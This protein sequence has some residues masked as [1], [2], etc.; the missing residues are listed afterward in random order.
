MEP[1]IAQFGNRGM[2]QDTSISKAPNEFA[3]E[4]RNIR[5]TAINGDTLLSVTN[6]K[7]PKEI[8]LKDKDSSAVSLEGIC[9]GHCIL[10][11]YIVL[12]TKDTNDYIYRLEDKGDYFEVQL[13][14]NGIFGFNLSNPIEAIGYYESEDIQKIYWVDGINQPRLINIIQ[15]A[16]SVITIGSRLD[17]VSTV[18]SFPVIQVEK[19]FGGQGIFPSGVIQYF[20]TQYNKFGAETAIIAASDINYI[21]FSDRGGKADET[22]NCSFNLTIS[23]V[24]TQFDYVRIYSAKRTTLNGPLEVQIVA[25]IPTKDISVSTVSVTDTNINQQLVDSNILYYL[26]GEEFIASTLEQK[27]NTL[28]FGNLKLKSTEFPEI[29][30]MQAA[31]AIYEN[32]A[33][34]GTLNN[35]FYHYDYQ[36]KNRSSSKVKY[37]KGG[38]TY[39]FGIQFLN[40][41]GKWSP[42]KSLGDYTVP[43]TTRPSEE[44]GQIKIPMLNYAGTNSI[45]SSEWIGYRILRAETSINTRRILAQGMVN[46][47]VFNYEERCNN[48]PYAISSW[49]TR[50]MSSGNSTHYNNVNNPIEIQCNQNDDV[51][52]SK[53]AGEQDTLTTKK[54]VAVLNTKL[55][56]GKDY[57]LFRLLSVDSDAPLSSLTA[58]DVHEIFSYSFR[59]EKWNNAI[60][61]ANAYLHVK[62]YDYSIGP[63]GQMIVLEEKDDNYGSGS[64]E[65][66]DVWAPL[67]QGYTEYTDYW[68]AYYVDTPSGTNVTKQ[69]EYF[70]DTSIVT[71]NSPEFDSV[72]NVIDDNDDIKFRIVGIAE[73]QN[74]F[75]GHILET[76]DGIAPF[77]STLKKSGSVDNAGETLTSGP[78]YKDGT[79]VW[80]GVFGITELQKTF[81]TQFASTYTIYMWHKTGQIVGNNGDW[82]NAE[83][84]KGSDLVHKIF[85]TERYS[86]NTQYFNTGGYNMN[87]CAPKAFSSNEITSVKLKVPTD[88]SSNG[89]VYYYGNYEKVVV[90]IEPYS[91][92]FVPDRTGTQIL[93]TITDQLEDANIK[94]KLND[95]GGG[96]IVLTGE[97]NCNDPVHVKY[98]VSNEIVFSF[99]N[100]GGRKQ[101]LPYIGSFGGGG[102]WKQ[103]YGDSFYTMTDIYPWSGSFTY[104]RNRLT[105]SGLNT[106]QKPYVFIGELY[107]DLTEPYGSDTQDVNEKLK[108][109]PCS[110]AT[111]I[112]TP[113]T[114]EGDTY[115][116]RWDCLKSYP[117]TEE[118]ENS[119]VDITSFM[120]ESHIN[121]DGRCDVN[122]SGTE[123]TSYR[124]DKNF[125]LMNDI[126]SQENSIFEYS[127]LDEKYNLDTFKNQITWSLAKNP[128][129]D[130][131]TWTHITMLNL[132][133]LDGTYGAITKLSC[134]NNALFAFQDRALS[135]I[136]YNDR[137]QISTE[138]N[139]PIEVQNSGKVQ[140]YDYISKQIGCKNKWSICQSASGIYFT[141]TEKKSLYRVN[142]EG[143]SDVSANCGMSMWFKQNISNN[144]WKAD[145]TANKS[146]KT[147]Y[148]AVTNDI[149]ISTDED[150]IVYNEGLQS[151]T[152][153]MPY[154]KTPL[155]F[156][157]DSKSLM[158]DA[159]TK[160]Y[161]MF[162]GKY[163]VDKD[164]NPIG[165]SIQYRL[166]P[167]P[168]ET[169]TFTNLELI[170]DYTDDSNNLLKTKPFSTIETWNEHQYGKED[171]EKQTNYFPSELK[172]KF[173]V[174]R[175][176][177]PRDTLNSKYGLDRMK[178]PWIFLKLN[179]EFEETAEEN[180][181][182]FHSLLVKYFK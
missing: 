94:Q 134:I 179:K 71:L 83:N 173:R 25:D 89:Y 45:I 128:T 181:M 39:R 20:V 18:N 40:N 180:L 112:G 37:F 72:R 15:P 28:F 22:I 132:L 52:V 120:V 11:K 26:G 163:N 95:L 147:S 143:L 81:N 19:D 33:L 29:P 87:I 75:Q 8:Q 178:N 174:W 107:R 148:D 90:S 117:F 141:D 84:Y 153:F 56:V 16:N 127:I 182:T 96:N 62:R 54:I 104:E 156:S 30:Y 80:N 73:I 167:E 176:N 110:E 131:D 7:G 66:I 91:I 46:P 130:I 4:N 35:Q 63:S 162:A 50:P 14:A 31:S 152:S 103:V 78:F 48:A 146:A 102:D 150:C 136:N 114:L 93:T 145:W 82:I 140:G 137:I 32:S 149:Y 115:Y 27:D 165:Y 177:I 5:I 9:L 119:V 1:K 100:L 86:R 49:I 154:K 97:P 144:P 42:I 175:A 171:L 169:K 123:I 101:T 3:Y 155:L 138:Q 2:Q 157:L 159:V 158:I 129:D 34:V 161:Q 58:N 57:R 151:F 60:D 111:P 61:N 43:L 85:G 17:F 172:N 164:D 113:A 92:S 142:S 76:S 51:T 21:T 125:N 170:A 135:R 6:E 44:N 105:G 53:T 122:R 67:P 55:D 88:E 47:T 108:W 124:P 41:K 109:I 38:E 139:T 12:F 116:Q 69:R 10:G 79:P 133:N 106:P 68:C 24:D 168:L 126:Y 13:L 59:E 166:N 64:A 121:L 36:L 23:G 74:S 99:N 70:V 98:K 118:D 77:A 160:F 65:N